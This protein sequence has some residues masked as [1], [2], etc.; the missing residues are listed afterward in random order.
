MNVAVIGASDNPEK[1]SNQAVC[2]LLEKGHRVFPVNPSGK[3]VENLTTYRSISEISEPIDTVT[4]YVSKP[5]S[6]QIASDL[7]AKKPR[8]IIFNPG[9]EN[10]DLEHQARQKGIVVQEACSLVL[11]RTNQF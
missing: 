7:F 5:V 11:L 9:A 4:L 1:Y 2:F 10:P 8:R 6:S 3:P